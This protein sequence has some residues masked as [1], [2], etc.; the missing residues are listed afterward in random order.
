MN[1]KT[2]LAGLMLLTA[3]SATATDNLY[4]NENRSEV[5]FVKN[6][7]WKPDAGYQEELRN[8]ANWQSFIQA[9]GTW[10]VMFNEENQRPYPA[11]GTPIQMAG[12][13]SRERAMNF[14]T[15]KLTGFN[16]PVNEL[17]FE[18]VVS[19]D[20]YDYVDYN[21]VHIG[22]PVLW[23]NLKVKMT[24][25]GAVIMFNANV[26]SDIAIPVSPSLSEGAAGAA[27]EKGIFGATVTSRY[28][29]PQV[30]ILPIPANRKNDY[31]LVYEVTVSG[32]VT[33]GP[34][35][36]YYT[37]VDAHT[38]EVYYR[39]NKVLHANG[40]TDKA[41]E[42]KKETAAAPAAAAANTDVYV[43]GTVYPTHPY[44]ASQL[45]LLKNLRFTAGT[46][47]YTDNAGYAG[48]PNTSSV[49][50]NFFTEGRW[51]DVMTGGATDQQ[52]ITLNPGVNNVTLTTSNIREL[53]GYYH[54]NIV[55]DYM[56]TKF[57][58]FT[59]MDNPLPT[60]IDVSG[61]CNA[62]YNGTSINF[63]AAGGGCN[64]LSQVGDVVYHEYGHG[65]ND[66]YYQS[67]SGNFGNGAL[68]EGYADIWAIGITE[69]PVLG[70]GYSSTDATVSVRRYDINKKVYPQNLVG[71]VHADGEI[72]AGA[73]WDYG[74]Y[75]GGGS[76]NIQKMMN[77]FK[78]TFNA[79]LTAPNGQ[80]G[81]L[82]VNVL[83]QALTDDD[84][85]SNGGDANIINGTP[86][87]NAI[88]NAFADHG[89][90][91][92]S[93]ANVTHT[94]IPS[95]AANTNITV[96]A[97]ITFTYAWALANAKLYYK[98]NKT[99]AWQNM[100]MTNTSGSNYTATIPM[101]VSGTII[102]YYIGLLDIYGKF[103]AVKPAGADKAVDPNLPYYILVG[104]NQVSIEDFDANQGNWLT[105]ITGDNATTGQW[106]VDIPLDSYVTFGQPQTIVQTGTQTTS[107]GV[108]C[109]LTANASSAS[110]NPG[111]ADVDAGQ[112]T[113][114]SPAYNL[115]TYTNPIFTYMRWY[116]N[117]K[118]ANPAN[119]SWEVQISNN[120]STWVKVERTFTA[121]ASWR[122]KAF[123]VK[124]F[125]TVS[126]NVRI[127]FVAEDSL[128]SG[129]LNGGS[130]VEAALDDLIL[131]DSG[132]TTDVNNTTA[133]TGVAVFPNPAKENASVNFSL[134]NA[135]KVEVLVI[136]AVGKVVRKENYGIMPA[137]LNKISI[138]LA[139]LSTGMYM[140][141]VKT[142]SG[143]SVQKFSVVK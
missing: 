106:V 38:G 137:G 44:N 88:I 72:I 61:T 80:E 26:Y 39:T 111:T 2:Y 43:R 85:I 143:S 109:A 91:L 22:V 138:D 17:N 45:V 79:K 78:T 58:S 57:P 108:A 32:Q 55:H 125:I 25:A 98:I 46:T 132:V 51:S 119:D 103:S 118:G 4:F 3:F 74:Q 117:D 133:V 135:E 11:F 14:I 93:N 128:T 65:I 20:D 116:S 107:G 76:A 36:E 49:T 89:I 83:V 112:T 10:Y 87:L 115:T 8:K 77:L 124:D 27:A 123:R 56:K 63:Y 86:N 33:D 94:A 29:N 64:C 35:V 16:I 42:A 122:R 47:Y 12:A 50:G 52:N 66:K 142:E 95:V 84:A 67:I 68:G 136:D 53:S 75:L 15:S 1:V 48:L 24:K 99:G 59:A 69:N 34:P 40:N 13:D 127:R 9:N 105:G 90:T 126:N 134:T 60:N 73:W 18:S 5:R 131:W 102:S 7:K 54:V 70:I 82:F 21:Q 114:E 97:N 139:D 113:L 19:G 30:K 121:D 41:K 81:S 104:C 140:I 28:V 110:D 120:G 92:L 71:E 141:N 62:F 101:Q 23:S 96:N 31:K 130:L 129:N 6:N 100:N 37:L